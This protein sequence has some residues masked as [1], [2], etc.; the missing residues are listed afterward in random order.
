M[1]PFF[2]GGS[3]MTSIDLL[4][5]V[6]GLLTTAS[7]IPQVVK[8]WRTRSTRDISLGMFIAFSLGTALWLIYGL[9]INS[10][11][12]VIANAFTMTFALI[13]LSLKLRHR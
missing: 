13:I 8:T 11:P 1:R 5:L 3:Y 4:G 6:A 12:V 2:I 10:M 9:L 7:F